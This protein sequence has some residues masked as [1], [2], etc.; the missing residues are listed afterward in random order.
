M[1]PKMAMLLFAGA[2]ALGQ[3]A[4]AQKSGPLKASEVTEAAITEALAPAAAA[5]DNAPRSRGFAPAMRPQPKKPSSAAVL[6]TFITD[7]SELTAESRSALDVIA[8]A[9]S[10]GRLSNLQ[11][12]VE[13]HADP[14]GEADHNMELSRARAESVVSYLVSE[15]RIERQR[16]VP[17]GKGASEPLNKTQADAPENRRV[18]F[19]TMTN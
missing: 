18:T 8:K 14:R 19:V 5:A 4:L 3:A 1:K 6:I 12:V 16:L 17:V 10:G 15:H 7:S 2:L 9:L 11:F 13:G